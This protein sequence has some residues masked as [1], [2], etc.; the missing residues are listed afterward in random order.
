MG[1]VTLGN[2]ISGVVRMGK[3]TDGVLWAPGPL[4]YEDSHDKIIDFLGQP[5]S[6]QTF[7]NTDHSI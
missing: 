5:V 3:I 4:H 1:V 7:V 6:V 2:C